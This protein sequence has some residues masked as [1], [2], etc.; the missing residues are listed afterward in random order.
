MTYC[1]ILARRLG[2]LLIAGLAAALLAACTNMPPEAAASRASLAGTYWKLLEAGGKAPKPQPGEPAAHIRFEAAGNRTSGYSA[3]NN[4][5]GS[6]EAEEF[7]LRFGPV[8]ATRRAGPPDAME[9]ESK[10]FIAFDATRSYRISGRSLELL[11]AGGKPL[12][13]FEAQPAP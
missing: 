7:K 10:L 9:V 4:F 1:D 12:A 11:D 13:R 3:V 6:Y 8:A 2:T 5:N